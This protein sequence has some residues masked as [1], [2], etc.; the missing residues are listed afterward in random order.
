[1]NN[2]YVQPELERWKEFLDEKLTENILNTGYLCLDVPE[3]FNLA[4]LTPEGSSSCQYGVMYTPCD[5]RELAVYSGEEQNRY[6]SGILKLIFERLLKIVGINDIFFRLVDS[7]TKTPPSAQQHFTECKRPKIEILDG[8]RGELPPISEKELPQSSQDKPK[9]EIEWLVCRAASVNIHSLPLSTPI[10]WLCCEDIEHILH[11]IKDDFHL[12]D[13]FYL[14]LPLKLKHPCT[15]EDKDRIGIDISAHKEMIIFLTEKFSE[16]SNHVRKSIYFNSLVGDRL[17]SRGG[18]AIDSDNAKTADKVKLIESKNWNKYYPTNSLRV[19]LFMTLKISTINL[20]KINPGLFQ[21][22]LFINPFYNSTSCPSCHF[23][24]LRLAKNIG[25]VDNKCSTSSDFDSVEKVLS[26]EEIYVLA[27]ETKI[28]IFINGPSPNEKYIKVRRIVP[29]RANTHRD[30]TENVPS[31]Y[32][33]EATWPG[34]TSKGVANPRVFIG[35][36]SSNSM[37]LGA[38]LVEDS[39]GSRRGEYGY[40][41][42]EEGEEGHINENVSGGQPSLEARG[43]STNEGADLWTQGGEILLNGKYGELELYEKN[44]EEFIFEQ[45]HDEDPNCCGS[46]KKKDFQNDV[47][48]GRT[49]V[50]KICSKYTMVPYLGSRSIL[51]INDAQIHGSCALG[52]SADKNNQ[53]RNISISLL[54]QICSYLS[55]QDFS[56]FRRV[57][58]THCCRTIFNSY[59]QNLTLFESDLYL[60]IMGQLYPFLSKAKS[61][62]L[63]Q[64]SDED[65]LKFGMYSPEFNNH[66]NDPNYCRIPPIE[67]QCMAAYTPKVKKMIFTNHSNASLAKVIS[68]AS[69]RK[70]ETIV[71]SPEF[72]NENTE[73]RFHFDEDNESDDEVDDQIAQEILESLNNSGRTNS[74]LSESNLGGMNVVRTGLNVRNYELTESML[75]SSSNLSLNTEQ[76]PRENELSAIDQS[77]LLNLQSFPD[78]IVTTSPSLI[79]IHII[80]SIESSNNLPTSLFRIPTNAPFRKLIRYFRDVTSNQEG[81]FDFYIIRYGIKDRLIPD[82]APIDYGILK[83]STVL[84]AIGYKTLQ[85]SQKIW[86]SLFLVGSVNFPYLP[87]LRFNASMNTPFSRLAESYSRN[88]NI[89]VNDIIFIYRDSEIDLALSP[90]DYSVSDNDTIE[91]ILRTKPSAGNSS[92]SLVISSY[93][94]GADFP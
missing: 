79:E 82:L 9:E 70:P 36:L 49:R 85:Y 87:K 86:I 40:G 56:A 43:E 60:P 1:M 77:L 47:T 42:G 80:G 15:H 25:G 7:K 73:I 17:E 84:F 12:H 27:L 14:C 18:V 50:V 10:N 21:T 6:V 24:W 83:G 26:D 19:G 67:V 54:S 57:C 68:R 61:I 4:K 62:T 39:H 13:M 91:V 20:F 65:N 69:G 58:R 88:V 38:K 22:P 51:K 89:S 30:L 90:C 32:S 29:K 71:I 48:L 3:G 66:M 76:H 93:G 81:I 94:I 59:I 78:S 53:N 28:R 2:L 8:H 35:P 74:V 31:T 23:S 64:S 46:N 37:V 63:I 52:I 44:M 5:I 34:I 55:I 16:F 75:L 92:G 72:I 41:E 11:T 45:I 33:G